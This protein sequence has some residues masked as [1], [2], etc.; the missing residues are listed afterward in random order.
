MPV[1]R[2]Y[3]SILVALLSASLIFLFA[4]D[5]SLPPRNDPTKL[6]RGSVD[7]KYSLLWNENAMRISVT[8]VN[9]FDETIQTTVSI[10][11]TVVVTL[12]R[13]KKYQKTIALNANNLMNTKF[14]NPSTKELTLDPGDSI[15]FAYTWNFVDDNNVRLP[16]DVFHFY[17]DPICSARYVAYSESFALTGS[18]QIIEK[19]G[20][21]PL[22]PSVLNL[23]Y[24]SLYVLPKDC[25]APPTEC[26]QR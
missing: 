18:I 11:G 2:N 14:Y 6:F 26:S 16:E 25:P 4:C 1:L 10:A 9:V 15:R 19:M 3:K 17:R 12:A 5:E 13:D 20:S 23:C 24:I 7:A 8:I 22:I 21:F